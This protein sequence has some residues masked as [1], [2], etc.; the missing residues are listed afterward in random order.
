MKNLFVVF[1][2]GG[3]GSAVRYSIS[4]FVKMKFVT[5]FPL[6]TLLSNVLSCVVMAVAIGFFAE[7]ME[8]NPT[9][10]L[11]VLVGFCGGFS[12]F[13]TFS[14]ETVELIR[15]GNSIYAITNILIS[16]VVCT[17]IIFF[18]TASLKAM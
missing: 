18:L 4:A 3:I 9:L 15:S 6:A 10:K 2:A 1:V 16:V 17:G 5:V 13:S 14:F 11:L 12:T 7:K 8:M